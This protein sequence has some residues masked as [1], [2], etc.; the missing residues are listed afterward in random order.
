[1]DAIQADVALLD[2]DIVTE[3]C[4]PALTTLVSNDHYVP[5]S[6]PGNVEYN[7]NNKLLNV[8]ASS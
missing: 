7:R 4:R 3:H 2:T 8:I 6:E 5:V 1:M